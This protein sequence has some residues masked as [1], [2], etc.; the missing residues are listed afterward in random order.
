MF[1][2]T[3]H[4]DIMSR[5]LGRRIAE[6]DLAGRAEFM[7]KAGYD[8]LPVVVSMVNPGKI[9]RDAVISKAI[10]QVML[11][12]GQGADD[13]RAWNLELTSFIHE[14]ADLDRFPWEAASRIDVD[15]L[16]KAREAL[17]EGMKAVAVSGKI[18]TLTWMLMGF[19]N[20]SLKLIMDESLV[21]DVFEK[22]ADIQFRAL[23]MILDMDHVGAVWAIDDL[24]F[25]TGAMISPQAFRDHIFPHYRKMAEMCHRRGLFFAFHSDGKLDELLEDLID[26]GVDLLHPIDPGCMDIFEVKKQ[27]GDRIC[28][29]GNVSNEMLRSGTPAQ[30]EAYVKELIQR[31]APGGGYCVA[32]G[33]SVPDWS[34]FE[35][36]MTLRETAL[37]YGRYPISPGLD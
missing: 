6:D 25:G 32:A 18:F 30:V 23:D 21:S 24:A 22:V 10:R 28:L 36:Y 34:D 33:N 16:R 31:C 20:F 27:V 12:N 35:N 11:K 26:L 5:F 17:P 13:E 4:E 7:A 19:N 9:S 14:R 8:F 2:G 37:T 15:A 3:I 1:E 29:A